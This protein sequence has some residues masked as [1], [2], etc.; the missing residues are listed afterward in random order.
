MVTERCNCLRRLSV[1]RLYSPQD[2]G[3]GV[4]GRGGQ[5][6]SSRMRWQSKSCLARMPSSA[7]S[8][9]P[10]EGVEP[11]LQLNQGGISR[12]PD[13]RVRATS[14]GR[15]IVTLAAG[16]LL[17]VGLTISH[18]GISIEKTRAPGGT[19]IG[20][21]RGNLRRG[22]KAKVT[23]LGRAALSAKR[24]SKRRGGAPLPAA[25]TSASAMLARGIS[26]GEESRAD[27]RGP[28]EGSRAA[29]AFTSAA[30]RASVC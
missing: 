17:G 24:S 15:L 21:A 22:S 6:R 18:L 30:A 5:R 9:R 11:F 28:A 14:A 23:P 2:E 20:A 13:R 4:G 19:T 3:G 12:W 10:A 7:G 29:A 16:K 27:P 26:G 8:R 25:G 1:A